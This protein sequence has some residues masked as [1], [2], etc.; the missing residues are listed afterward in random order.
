M[1]CP[2]CGQVNETNARFCINCGFDFNNTLSTP[3]IFQ[4]TPVEH[5]SQFKQEPNMQQNNQ[6]NQQT[7]TQQ[8]NSF[9]QAVNL[10]SPVGFTEQPNNNV[11]QSNQF[12]EQTATQIPNQFNQ[13]NT[14]QQTNEINNQTI[15][16]NQNNIVQESLKP[17][18]NNKTSIL[19]LIFMI[20]AVFLK[21]TSTIKEESDKLSQIKNSLTLSAIIS[22]F[23]TIISLIITMI[24]TVYVK[25]Y[26]I[27]TGKYTTTVT[28][29]NLKNVKYFEVIGKYFIVYLGIMLIIAGVYY[30]VGL[31]LKKQSNFSKLLGIATVS[32]FPALVGLTIGYPIMSLISST[33]GLIVGLVGIIYTF[34]IIYENIN[35][36]FDLKDNLRVYFNLI[37]VSLILGLS[38]F[39][40]YKLIFENIL[41]KL[42]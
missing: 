30:L 27:F 37:S 28:W 38:Y 36:E 6:I 34:V 31:I 12:E 4:Q 42:F 26:N 23:F 10:E 17:V 1:N 15:S 14:M 22:L 24:N 18:N 2:K 20:F 9:N 3:S 19:Y 5:P 11:Q 25:N 8:V 40:S 16:N 13:A 29:S 7:T 32:I 35:L 39:L 41:K 21:P 33:L